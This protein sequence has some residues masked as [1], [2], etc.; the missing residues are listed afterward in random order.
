MDANEVGLW[1]FTISFMILVAVAL[2]PVIKILR[3]LLSGDPLIGKHGHD[4]VMLDP[5]DADY[6]KGKNK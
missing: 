6:K 4:E 1:V 3:N 2:R 5:K